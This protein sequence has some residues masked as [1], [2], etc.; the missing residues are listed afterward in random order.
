MRESSNLPTKESSLTLRRSHPSP[1]KEV[2]Q[3]LESSTSL[4]RSHPLSYKKVIYHKYKGVIHLLTKKSS[5][6]Q[7]YHPP[8]YKKCP[9]ISSGRLLPHYRFIVAV[10]PCT[11]LLPRM[12]RAGHCTVGCWPVRLGSG[13][14]HSSP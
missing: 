2:I 9:P 4:Q 6:L 8:P 5:T 3:L 11:L 12:A 14:W 13:A 1:Y 7:I 10:V